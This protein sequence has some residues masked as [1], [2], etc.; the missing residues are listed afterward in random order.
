MCQACPPRSTNAYHKSSDNMAAPMI[1]IPH[2]QGDLLIIQQ[3][4]QLTPPG[5]HFG[6]MGHRTMPRGTAQIND[7]ST[8]CPHHCRA[9]GRMYF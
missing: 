4:L 5:T 9:P 7:I 6:Q 2:E 8:C 1:A 3:G